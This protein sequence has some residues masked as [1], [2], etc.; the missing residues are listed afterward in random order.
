MKLLAISD[1][2]IPAPIMRE[3][4]ESLR[5]VGMDVETRPWEHESLSGLQEANLAIE[6]GGPEAVP[7]PGSLLADCDAFH[8]LVVQFAPVSRR[9][10]ERASSLQLVCVLRGG[11]EN[12]D[13][14]FATERGI[15]VMNTPGRN[16]RA[17]AECTLA[18]M[19]AEVRNIAR[20]H[21]A[22]KS[23][24][25]RRDFPNTEAIPELNQKT[26]G[27]VGYGA[28]GR[29]VARYLTAFGSNVVTHDPFLEQDPA[30]VRR[31]ELAE[32]LEQSDIVSLHARLTDDNRHLIGRAELER[33][34]PTAVL[35]NTA[36]SG[37]VDEDALVQAL[38][39]KRIMGAAIDVFDQE[40]LPP[41]HPLLTLDNV[42]LT[43]HLAGSTIDA[44][45]GS[46]AL[47]AGHLKRLMRG[48][49]NV[50]IVNGIRPKWTDT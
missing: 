31:V 1:T 9:L 12:V 32:L 41:E 19:L 43:P 10:L 44:F 24:L 28:V 37:L 25:W 38:A 15:S 46:P 5:E 39:E 14:S 18:L 45:R 23:G 8:V 26:V 29:L 2:Y 42:T 47:L 33:M 17:V 48:D 13:V 21:A 50:P 22:L 7:L 11:T 36:R 16:A 34:K 30:A 35:V 49:H 27:L 4:L 40:P 3:G 6:Q 20:A